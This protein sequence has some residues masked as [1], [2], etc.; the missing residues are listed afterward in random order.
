[1]YRAIEGRVFTKSGTAHTQLQG[2]RVGEFSECEI[3]LEYD[4]L[5]PQ[6]DTLFPQD[7]FVVYQDGDEF[8]DPSKQGAILTLHEFVTQAEPYVLVLMVEKGTGNMSVSK[9]AFR[10]TF[11]THSIMWGK[12]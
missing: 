7:V 12:D 8:F 2:V 6:L 10:H 11:K 3:D 4:I 5:P 9:P 1:M